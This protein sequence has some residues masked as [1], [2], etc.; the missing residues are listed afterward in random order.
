MEEGKGEMSRADGAVDD[1]R[2]CMF[3]TLGRQHVPRVLSDILGANFR[4]L[5]YSIIL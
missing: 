2:D 4:G 3:F 1:G 5:V